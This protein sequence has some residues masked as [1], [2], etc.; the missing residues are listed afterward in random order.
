MRNMRRHLSCLVIIASMG[1]AGHPAAWADAAAVGEPAP[2][3]TLTDTDGAPRSLSDFGARWVV[4][5]WSNHECPFVRKHYGSGNMQ[6]LQSTYTQRGVVWLTIVSAAPGKQGSVTVEQ[7][8]A[9]RRQRGDRQTAMLLDPDGAVG[10]LYGAKT[11]PH[12]FLIDPTGVLVYAGAIDDKPS[13]DPAD[14]A[15]AT[16]YIERALEEADRDQ[17]ISISHTQSYGCSIK[18]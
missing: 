7:A 2:G 4:L 14:I 10:R 12:M 6:R 13:T 1:W 15:T 5:E 11:T 9:I 8:N 17:T 3:F 18:Y 16:N